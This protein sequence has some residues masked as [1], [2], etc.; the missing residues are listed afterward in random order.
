MV[1]A[2]IAV[3]AGVRA[4]I[5]MI[6]AAEVDALVWPAIQASMRRRVRAVRLGRP[7]HREAE[8]VG[9]LGQRQMVGGR[10]PRGLVAEAES[11]FASYVRVGVPGSPQRTGTRPPPSAEADT[12]R[13]SGRRLHACCG[14]M[15]EMDYEYAPLR[16]PPN[17]DRMTAAVQ[18]T[19]AAEYAGWELARV[20]TLPRWHP[21]GAAAPQP[22]RASAARS[23][24]LDLLASRRQ[25]V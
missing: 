20:Q 21:P 24:V 4:G 12:R 23:L 11:E 17:V 7:H 1:A 18:L 10:G 13:G 3:I 14:T 6:A 9:L 15:H 19:I 16:L 5:C 25:R 8:P 2:V 22:E